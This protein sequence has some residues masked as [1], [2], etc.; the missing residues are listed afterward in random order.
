M[1]GSSRSR[2]IIRE[3]FRYQRGNDGVLVR[4]LPNVWVISATPTEADPPSFA[5]FPPAVAFSLAD[6]KAMTLAPLDI[7]RIKDFTDM[8]EAELA[9]EDARRLSAPDEKGKVA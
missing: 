4:T 2:T 9:A 3:A 1:S 7:I 8:R 6:A 5:L